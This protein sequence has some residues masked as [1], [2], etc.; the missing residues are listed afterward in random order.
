MCSAARRALEGYVAGRLEADRVVAAVTAA[1]YRETGKG[2]R[3][4]GNGKGETAQGEREALRPVIEVVE[5]AA[6]GV[7]ELA[8]RADGPGFEVRVVERPFPKQYEAE[9]RRAAEAVLGAWNTGP[10]QGAGKPPADA[11]WMSRL[12]RAV[13]RLFHA[14]A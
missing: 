5:R 2:E 10:D 14:S 3:E 7:V 13:L 6:P 1:Y 12:V 9:L 4:T 11:G 8:G